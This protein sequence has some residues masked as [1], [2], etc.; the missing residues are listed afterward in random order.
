MIQKCV[1]CGRTD[2]GVHALQFYAHFDSDTEISDFG[3]FKHQLN[4]LL[5]YEISIIKV[6]QSNEKGHTRFDAEWR[7][8]HYVISKGKNAFL[9]KFA[10]S[11]FNPLNIGTMNE[12]SE[13]L[14]KNDDFAAFCKKGS[15]VKTTLCNVR[16]AKWTES[17]HLYIFEISA[18]RFLRGMVRATTGTLLKVG[19][20]NMSVKQFKKVI[21]S[22]DRQNAGAALPACGLFLSGV[23]YPYIA[24]HEPFKFFVR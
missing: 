16:S 14:I 2:S 22:K 1:G 4:G 6:L 23:T 20:G 19:E 12:A 9:K 17:D 11:V 21:L 15:D 3:V 18:N 13:L 8:Y 7:T 5:P 24:D 10:H